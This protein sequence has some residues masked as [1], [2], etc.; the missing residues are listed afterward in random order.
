MPYMDKNLKQELL[1][2]IEEFQVQTNRF[3]QKELSVK[4]VKGY[5]GGFGSYAQRGA[6]SFMLRLR[7]TQGV[8]TKDRLKFICD[9]CE[10]HQ[11]SKS[12]FTPCQTIQLPDLTGSEIPSIMK[13]A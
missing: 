7:M 13:A 6:Q 11:V 5:S 2:E 8:I 9:V 4:E 10:E 1:E 12:H 3:L